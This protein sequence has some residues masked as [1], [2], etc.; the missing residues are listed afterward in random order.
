[1]EN[2]IKDTLK[3]LDG[4]TAR[5]EAEEI[6]R[7]AKEKLAELHR[8]GEEYLESPEMKKVMEETAGIEVEFPEQEKEEGG[9][10]PETPAELEAK[11][12][13]IKKRIES[14]M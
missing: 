7:K 3:V 12:E 8:I 9:P 14:S 2:K 11:A 6:E 1:M 4:E 5:K 13:E 10:S